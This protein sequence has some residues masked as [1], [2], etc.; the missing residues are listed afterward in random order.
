MRNLTLLTDLYQ[1]TMRT[2]TCATGRK[3][4]WRYSIC[5][6]RRNGIISYSVAAGL[7]QAAD[8]VRGLRF[9]EEDIAYLRS[10]EL[11]D[12]SFPR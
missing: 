2:D 3:R 11:F 12:E 8:Y 1:L 5:F 10:L 7:Q 6:F 9:E 4:M